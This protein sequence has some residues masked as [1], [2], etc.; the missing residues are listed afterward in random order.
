MN[1]QVNVLGLAMVGA[2]LAVV[3]FW[4]WAVSGYVSVT[5]TGP[6]NGV[7][8]GEKEVV[9]TKEVA[10]DGAVVQGVQ[11]M[12]LKATA[13]GFYE[14]SLLTVKKGIPVN[15]HF[16]AEP[17]SG[18][19]KVLVI[20]AFKVWKVAPNTGEVLAQFT[21]TQ[22]GVFDFHCSMRMFRGKLEVVE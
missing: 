14:P 21:P 17:N 16:S 4:G 6:A 8:P 1:V 3:V 22:K 18:C 15:L 19:G 13:K 7:S 10:S 9:P 11:E 2:A 20:P 5:V 12:F